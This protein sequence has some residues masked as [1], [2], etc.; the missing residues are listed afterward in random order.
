LTIVDCWYYFLSHW[1]LLQK[2][3]AYLFLEVFSLFFSSTSYKLS[4]LTLRSSNPFCNIKNIRNM[5]KNVNMIPSKAHISLIT[6]IIE[7]QFK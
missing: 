7:M 4:D 6:E 1:I 3:I 2:T 5:R